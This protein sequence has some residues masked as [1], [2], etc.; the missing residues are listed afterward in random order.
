VVEGPL[1][2]GKLEG[3][4]AEQAGQLAPGGERLLALGR[5][6]G[7]GAVE[8][9][10]PAVEHE[11]LERMKTE[12]ARVRRERRER[13]RAARMGDPGTGRDL[14]GRVRN[15]AVGDA[16][17]DEI[18]LAAVERPA[19]RARLDVLGEPGRG[20]LSDAPSADYAYGFDHLSTLQFPRDTGHIKA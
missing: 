3:R 2:I 1:L 4:E 15:G 9:L 20:G 8:L 11:G 12:S 10:G 19:G 7:P 18:D 13:R 17:Q 16:E 5:Q 6:G 14:G